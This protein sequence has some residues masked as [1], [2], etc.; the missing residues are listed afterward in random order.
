MFT[1]QGH[2][3]ANQLDSNCITVLALMLQER[4][5]PLNAEHRVDRWCLL[6]T[7]LL[8]HSQTKLQITH[9]T[10]YCNHE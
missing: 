4:R 5:L 10:V 9:Q 7:S 6:F 8:P 2:V 1:F 3:Y